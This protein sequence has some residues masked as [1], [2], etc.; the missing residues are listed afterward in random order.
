MRVDEARVNLPR[1]EGGCHCGALRFGVR[2]EK[3]ELLRCNC[4]MCTKRG[5]LHLIVEAHEFTLL[6]GKDDIQEYRFGT[7]VARHYFCKHC[8]ITPF[9]VP[10]S[11]PQG[12]SVNF[13]CI[14]NFEERLGDYEIRD[15]DGARWEENIDKIL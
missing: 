13:R 2:N 9:Y 1:T 5:H 14:D 11:H 10:R 3:R 6:R 12:F 7:K 8:G 15:F 4:S